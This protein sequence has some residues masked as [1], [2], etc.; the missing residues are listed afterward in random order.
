MFSEESGACSVAAST[1]SNTWFKAR[2]RGG[3]SLRFGHLY[4]GGTVSDLGLR[5]QDAGVGVQ[6]TGGWKV[7]EKQQVLVEA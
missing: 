7:D 4:G 2:L 6:V 5:I 1:S 3:W